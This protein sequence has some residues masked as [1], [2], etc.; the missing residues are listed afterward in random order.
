[1]SEDVDRIFGNP[2]VPEVAVTFH[3]QNLGV[4]IT[5]ALQAELT[6]GNRQQAIPALPQLMWEPGYPFSAAIKIKS[7]HDLP[8]KRPHRPWIKGL[9]K[10]APEERKPALRW[11]N[12]FP[13]TARTSNLEFEPKKLQWLVRSTSDLPVDGKAS[14]SRVAVL[15][16]GLLDHEADMI[17]FVGC[18][19]K[20]PVTAPSDDLHGHGTAVAH[21]IRAVN[22]NADIRP[23]R[24]LNR[25]CEGHS[26]EVISALIWAL[27][28]GKYDLI[29]ASLSS[30]VSGS[31]DSALGRSIDY[32]LACGRET[33][34]TLPV[35][36]A[37]AGNNK[38]KP[39]GY[40]AR[41]HGAI[42]A[43]A[44]DGN[45]QHAEYNSTPPPGSI[46]A[47]AYGG[48]ESDP[49]GDLTHLQIPNGPTGA[50]AKIW[51]TSFAAAAVSGAY[52]Q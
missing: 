6:A 21:A 36:V 37:A 15:D 11:N 43:L 18:D 47:M 46:S 33:R 16:T 30:P 20:G 23:I 24:V 32:V 40:P 52:L 44:L 38:D 49:L 5:A 22:S 51:G 48:E 29:N 25:R 4:H 39:S 7:N 45:S 28:S 9:N 14:G 8:E 27:F 17:D 13:P 2:D 42:V 1:M 10:R 34:G 19:R 41:L 12:V 3:Q 35:L 26:Y 50:E 31:C